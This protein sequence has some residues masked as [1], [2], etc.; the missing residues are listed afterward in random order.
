MHAAQ[1]ASGC[2]SARPWRKEELLKTIYCRQNEYHLNH[3]AQSN[4]SRI[5]VSSLA[6]AGQAKY[7]SMQF[8][9]GCTVTKGAHVIVGCKVCH[10]HPPAQLQCCQCMHE[11]ARVT[12]TIRLRL[13]N[14]VTGSRFCHVTFPR[15]FLQWQLAF[16]T[17]GKIIYSWYYVKCVFLILFTVL[18][19]E[20][21]W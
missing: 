1:R 10:W 20:H 8:D 2:D 18:P 21:F 9:V 12:W 15:V 5:S 7:D 19:S 11:P 16:D 6:L 4:A 13:R 17:L 3:R 14:C